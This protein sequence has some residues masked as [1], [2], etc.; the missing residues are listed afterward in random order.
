[1]KTRLATSA[2]FDAQVQHDVVLRTKVSKNTLIF[3]DN[4]AKCQSLITREDFGP[5]EMKTKKIAQEMA[6]K[7]QDMEAQARRWQAQETERIRAELLKEM[8]LQQ[9]KDPDGDANMETS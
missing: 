5:E 6:K 3:K 8:G 1:M 9:K 7:E 4:I 2:P